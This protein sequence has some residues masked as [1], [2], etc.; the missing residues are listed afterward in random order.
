MGMDKAEAN[1]RWICDSVVRAPMA[2]QL[3]NSAVNWGEMVSVTG[4]SSRKRRLSQQQFRST[5]PPHPGI[6]KQLVDRARQDLTGAVVQFS[7]PC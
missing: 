6:R 3:V 1:S 5:H 4:Q 2:P 7:D